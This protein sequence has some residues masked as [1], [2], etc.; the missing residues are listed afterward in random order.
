MCVAVT[1]KPRVIRVGA[2]GREQALRGRTHAMLSRSAGSYFRLHLHRAGRLCGP[3][4][5]LAQPGKRGRTSS[6][7]PPRLAVRASS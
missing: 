2:Y 1:G 7:G 5:P 3:M 6:P 4:P